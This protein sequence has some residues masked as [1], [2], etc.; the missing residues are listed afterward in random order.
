M[1]A[2]PLL[3]GLLAH[4]RKALFA[5]QSLG[6]SAGLLCSVAPGDLT[7]NSDQPEIRP[8]RFDVVPNRVT[9]FEADWGTYV[10]RV[11]ICKY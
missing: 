10:A 2:S 3:P 8:Q 9:R 4:S 11:I 5:A 6:G 1:P 7:A